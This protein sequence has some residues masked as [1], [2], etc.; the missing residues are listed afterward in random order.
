MIKWFRK[1]RRIVRNYDQEWQ[2]LENRCR[3]AE[4]VIRER[5]DINADVAF[6]ARGTSQIIMMGRYKNRDF[7]QIYSLRDV[8][9]EGMVHRLR[10]LERYGEIRKVDAPMGMRAVFESEFKI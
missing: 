9:F 7:I 8:D 3:S 6:H 10:E 1:L 4:E 5:T 2:F